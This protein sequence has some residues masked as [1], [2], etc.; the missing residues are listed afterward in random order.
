VEQTTQ[1]QFYQTEKIFLLK[2]TRPYGREKILQPL[3]AKRRGKVY[4]EKNL[5]VSSA[6]ACMRG[7]GL[8]AVGQE[9][10]PER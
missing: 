2:N 9:E 6:G 10:C 4:Y 8:R 1:K 5:F 3:P 7:R